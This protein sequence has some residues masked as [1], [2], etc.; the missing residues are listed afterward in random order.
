MAHHARTLRAVFFLRN[1][2]IGQPVHRPS[3]NPVPIDQAV[4]K[5]DLLEANLSSSRGHG[6]RSWHYHETHRTSL[7][8][9]CN[10]GSSIAFDAHRPCALGKIRRLS[11][12]P[13]ADTGS[14]KENGN[15]LLN[16]S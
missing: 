12:L 14:V 16:H 4:V 6:H 3:N 13:A 5:N 2:G 7:D 11:L 15:F 8:P 10:V 1:Q 9:I